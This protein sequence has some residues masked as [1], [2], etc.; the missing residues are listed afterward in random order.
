MRDL[1][2]LGT[3]PRILGKEVKKKVLCMSLNYVKS[4]EPM[5]GNVQACTSLMQTLLVHGHYTNQKFL[6]DVHTSVTKKDII[7]ALDWLVEDADDGDVMML[8][9]AGRGKE[10]L[11]LSDGEEFDDFSASLID[12]LPGKTTLF[13]LS[14]VCL[15]LNSRFLCKDT[16]PKCTSS[17]QI[18]SKHMPTLLSTPET[19]RFEDSTKQETCCTLISVYSGGSNGHLA[20]MLDTLLTTV[21]PYSVSLQVFLQHAQ[22]CMVVNKLDN[23]CS[24]ESGQHIDLQVPIGR[25]LHLP[26]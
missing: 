8:I 3:E 19:R 16:S 23:E 11:E 12:F 21:Y 24:L 26:I 5:F 4:S 14:D 9:I 25:L 18:G 13:M 15:P 2:G 10:G 1:F 6:T 7:Q 22:A 20:F 17:K